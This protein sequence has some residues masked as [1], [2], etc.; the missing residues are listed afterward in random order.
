MIDISIAWLFICIV[1]GILTILLA[2]GNSMPPIVRRFIML[3]NIT[4]FWTSCAIFFW[5]ALTIFMVV[6]HNPPL[7]F[8]PN[9]FMLFVLIIKIPEHTMLQTYKS[10]GECNELAIWRSQ[11]SYTICAPLHIMSLVQGTIAAWGIG[12][13]KIDKSFWTPSDHGVEVIRLVTIWVTFIWLVFIFC[14][15]FTTTMYI[16]FELFHNLADKFEIGCQFGAC[17][18]MLLL[19]ITVWEPLISVWG[20]TKSINDLS[21]DKT[22]YFA[23]WWASM[24]IWWRSRAWIV[25]YMV[26][27]GLPV[28]ILSGITTGLGLLTPSAYATTV[29]GFRV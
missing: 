8:N 21:T 22:R 20:F 19:A 14:I 24:C 16:R 15:G 28:L 2:I 6:G 10:M 4:Y 13:K 5:L 3:E 29:Q 12:F 23:R 25:R 9:H 26:D 17:F 7:M 27:F 18:L 1:V 11:Q